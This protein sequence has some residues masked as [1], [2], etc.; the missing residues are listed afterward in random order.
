[1]VSC[2][3]HVKRNWLPLSETFIFNTVSAEVANRSV[4]LYQY[5]ETNNA[6]TWDDMVCVPFEMRILPRI[7]TQIQIRSRLNKY[8]NNQTQSY[9]NA[10]RRI[11]PDIVHAHFGPAAVDVMLAAQQ[12]SIPLIAAFHGYDY[13]SILRETK[14][15]VLYG[16]LWEIAGAVTCS[17]EHAKK[18]LVALGCPSSKITILKC[19][20][21]TNAIEFRER[22]PVPKGERLTFMSVGRLVEK[23]GTIYSI[24]AMAEVVKVFP[25]SQLI[26]IGGGDL[27]GPL[28]E[29][30]AE[31]GLMGNVSLLGALPHASVRQHLNAGHIFLMPSVT[32]DTGDVESQGIALQEAQ[33]S[34]MPVLCSNN[35]GLAGGMVD[36]ESGYIF[37]E[38]DAHSQAQAMIALAGESTRWADMG[39]A[40]RRF[41]EC[42]YSPAE[43]R[44]I[45]GELYEALSKH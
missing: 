20:V 5:L 22:V 42:E 7:A 6:L 33:A 31:L 45:L 38:R 23:K 25:D 28:T 13:S 12:L 1:M 18:C 8:A 37:H 35:P 29:R 27:H 24:E 10:L 43:F 15:R 9:L 41:V 36:G 30:I 44:R 17:G 26:H 21:D 11:A 39:R 4:V 32:A 34:G 16:R 14:W 3:A 40:G 19:P 2:V